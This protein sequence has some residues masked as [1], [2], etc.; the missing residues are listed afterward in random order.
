[1]LFVTSDVVY[2]I[3][4]MV[5]E[6]AV[7]LVLPSVVDDDSS[8][9]ASV[10]EVAL[11]DLAHEFIFRLKKKISKI[12][13]ITSFRFEIFF[14]EKEM[15]MLSIPNAVNKNSHFGIMDRSLEICW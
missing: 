15:R 8:E 2:G 6:V 14:N 3:S 9:V 10:S 4:F 12:S 7:V 13:I 5:T 11:S 1:M